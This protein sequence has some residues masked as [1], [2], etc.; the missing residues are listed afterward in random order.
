MPSNRPLQAACIKD[1]P[2]L[3]LIL[4][5]AG[6]DRSD[7]FPTVCI[8]FYHESRLKS[9]KLYSN[10]RVSVFLFSDR[11]AHHIETA[12]VWLSSG[13]TGSILLHV[14]FT[15]RCILLDVSNDTGSCCS[16]MFS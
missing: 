4:A 3:S 1:F 5:V 10:Q 8:I 7:S 13:Q 14:E 16:Q 15:L 9:E 11:E 6:F 12:D 2:A